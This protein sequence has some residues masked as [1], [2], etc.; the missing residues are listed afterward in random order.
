MKS[1]RESKT[2]RQTD[3]QRER[4]RERD[5]GGV[6]GEFVI[7]SNRVSNVPSENV[8]SAVSKEVVSVV[9]CMVVRTC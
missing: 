2:D 3:R 8:L 4:V 9:S 7:F 6:G 1:G 5:G